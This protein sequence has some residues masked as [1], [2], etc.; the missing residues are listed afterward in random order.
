MRK[1]SEILAQPPVEQR[2]TMTVEERLRA[3]WYRHD[4]FRRWNDIQREREKIRMIVRRYN[5]RFKRMSGQG[6]ENA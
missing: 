3:D 2:R 4:T 6:F 1:R 5:R